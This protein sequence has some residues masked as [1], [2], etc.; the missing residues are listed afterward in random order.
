MATFVYGQVYDLGAD[1]DDDYPGYRYAVP[2]EYAAG[3]VVSDCWIVNADGE[4]CPGYCNHPVLL[5]VDALTPAPGVT[6]PITRHFT[7]L[8]LTEEQRYIL[9]QNR[10]LVPVER[11]GDGDWLVLDNVPPQSDVFPDGHF[12]PYILTIDGKLHDV[13]YHYSECHGIYVPWKI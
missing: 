6:I 3:K 4:I 13:N 2:T 9:E 1:Y 11:L 7:G 10:H 12:G 5:C 8:E